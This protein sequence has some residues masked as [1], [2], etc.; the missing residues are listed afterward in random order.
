MLIKRLLQI[1]TR[2]SKQLF[3]RV[4]SA[5]YCDVQSKDPLQEEL[6]RE[7]EE[8][9]ANLDESGLEKM[10]EIKQLREILQGENVEVPE[11][12]PITSWKVL[13]T[14]HNTYNA[15]VKYFRKLYKDEL[16]RRNSEEKKEINRIKK[17]KRYEELA[18][19]FRIPE[20][21]IN[22]SPRQRDHDN[23]KKLKAWHSDINMI[24]DLDFKQRE[25]EYIHSATQIQEIWGMNK[26]HLQPLNIHLTSIDKN[27]H[28]AR[29]IKYQKMES[30][31]VHKEHFSD[32]FDKSDL[33]YL[34]PDGPPMKRFDRDCTYIVGGFVDLANKKH[35]TLGIARQLGIRTASFPI[36]TYC[37]LRV[38]QK[39]TI[40]T[41][42]AVYGILLDMYLHG[43]WEKA[44][45]KNLGSKYPLYSDVCVKKSVE[46]M[47]IKRY[48]RIQ[49]ALLSR[50]R[51]V[52]RDK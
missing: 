13:I 17:Q 52:L 47:D 44:F 8:F 24:F 36:K 41:L 35:Q 50:K 27:E 4:P 1:P 30:C 2:L 12:I 7:A 39:H 38:Y 42:N 49:D 10:N 31:T 21:S 33:V 15:R 14:E 22:Y 28:I 45:V 20:F 25:R 19:N 32:L 26:R 46:Y 11:T 23:W 48:E 16:R 29:F 51:D 3:W 9:V 40:L 37:D 6:L 5:A 43:S 34:T 18:A